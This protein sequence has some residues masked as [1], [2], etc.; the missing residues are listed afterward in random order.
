MA[1]YLDIGLSWAE[2]A[3][4]DLSEKLYFLAHVDTDKRIVLAGAG[5]I[6]FGAITETAIEDKPVTIQ[7]GGVAKVVCGAAVTAGQE[8][9]S[10]AA[11]EAIPKAGANY[12]FG[13]ALMSGDDGDII[14]VAITHAG[15]T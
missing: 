13:I 4:E 2:M 1:T 3:G 6:V 8:V 5:E 12:G 14:S 7:F 10:D 9:A 15:I 11:G